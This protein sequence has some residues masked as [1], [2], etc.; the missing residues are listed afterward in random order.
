MA[1]PVTVVDHPLLQDALARLRD[2][3]TP[4]PAFRTLTRRAGQALGFE[5]LRDLPLRRTTVTTPL[6]EAEVSLMEE[7]LPA[8][9]TIL[10]A[11]NGLLEGLMDLIPEAPVGHLGLYRD[12][13]TLQAVEYYRRLPPLL[14]K[15]I[16][17]VCDP[18]L[19]TGHTSV[20]ALDRLR[21]S[22]AGEIRYLCI[23]AAPEG[24]AALHA[25]HPEVPIWTGSVD[26]RLNDRGYI[27]PGLGDAGDRLYGTV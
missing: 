5:A 14:S 6:T 16:V 21:E 20:A 2:R 18:M 4:P 12:H 15:R 1:A 8:F 19:A 17:L 27:L 23:L 11:G 7:P 26:L 22:G 25:A 24:I 13:K 10:R 9:V 3:T